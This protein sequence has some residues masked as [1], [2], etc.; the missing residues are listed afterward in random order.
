MTIDL[1]S[2]PTD[3][4]E[5]KGL[6]ILEAWANGVPVVQPAAGAFPELVGEQGAGGLLV[7]QR[8]SPAL[9]NTWSL[10]LNDRSQLLR[11]AQSGYQK[12]RDDHSHSAVA[13]ITMRALEAIAHR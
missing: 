4:E 10:L 2:V 1:L 9:A 3:F 6:P 13:R 7:P 11:L 5:P 12:V 8:D